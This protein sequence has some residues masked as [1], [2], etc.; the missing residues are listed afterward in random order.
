M[1]V[2]MTFR[3]LPVNE[4]LPFLRFLI[5]NGQNLQG[6]R[7]H[8]VLD[9]GFD[10]ADYRDWKTHERGD[11]LYEDS[12]IFWQNIVS[13]DVLCQDDIELRDLCLK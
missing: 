13:D 8:T 2:F 1:G 6:K 4:I 7:T 9:M 3:E 10:Y 11:F 5:V 12:D